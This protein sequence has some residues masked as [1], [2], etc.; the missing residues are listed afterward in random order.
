MLNKGG[1]NDEE[2]A[3]IQSEETD[4]VKIMTIHKAK[5]LEFPIVIVGDTSGATQ[6]RL[7]HCCSRRTS[8]AYASLSTARMKP[9]RARRS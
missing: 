5:G 3:A 1:L 2:Q 9:N 6:T 7:N 8:R 4:A